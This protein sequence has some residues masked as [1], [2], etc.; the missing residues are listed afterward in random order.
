MFYDDISGDL[1]LKLYGEFDILS[2]LDEVQKLFVRDNRFII[3]IGNTQVRSKMYRKFSEVGGDLVSAISPFARIGNY[4][5]KIGAGSIVMSN[6]VITNDVVIGLSC[7][8]NPNCTISHDSVIGD[9]VD[10]SPAVN[11]TGNCRIGNFCSIGTNATILPNNKLSNNVVVGA[12]AV[13]TKNISAN[14]IVVGIPA[15]ERAKN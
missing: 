11:I 9:F 2:N 15:K 12:G 14:Q 10:I 4:G 5:T 1:P 3:A 7:L 6:A 13:V 8:I